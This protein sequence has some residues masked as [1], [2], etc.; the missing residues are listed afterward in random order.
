[1]RLNRELIEIKHTEARYVLLRVRY[2]VVLVRSDV[3]YMKQVPVILVM[4]IN[5]Y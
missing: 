2:L 4:S 1:M 3:P 5:H